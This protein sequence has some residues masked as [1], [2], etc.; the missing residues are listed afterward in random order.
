MKTVGTSEYTL[1]ITGIQIFTCNA[2]CN[3]NQLVTY[4]ICFERMELSTVFTNFTQICDYPLDFDA[5]NNNC[6]CID[7]Y[8]FSVDKCVNIE[9]Q[10]LSVDSNMQLLTLTMQY[11]LSQTVY[12]LNQQLQEV[13]Q[14]INDQLINISNNLDIHKYDTKMELNSINNT[15]HTNLNNN[16]DNI[17]LQF[18]K[19]TT[20][21]QVINDQITQ[22]KAESVYKL[23]NVYQV[24]QDLKQLQTTHLTQID[25]EI[26]NVEQKLSSSLTNIVNTVAACS[27]E[28][29]LNN[30]VDFINRQ[31]NELK[32]KMN[33]L[34][35]NISNQ[36]SGC[37]TVGA[38]PEGDGLC[39]CTQKFGIPPDTNQGYTAHGY[40]TIFYPLYNQCCTQYFYAFFQYES[41]S[42]HRGQYVNVADATL[43]YCSNQQQY[44][45]ISGLEAQNQPR[46]YTNMIV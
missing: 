17:N 1:S 45:Y 46:P 44:T 9:Q 11:E 27:K 33:E 8:Y 29:T 32:A 6:F 12:V 2:V 19:I 18:N 7:G 25:S 20:S 15:L 24:V 36:A 4:G 31:I 23:D 34:S 13:E 37:K 5:I 35:I 43:F 42:S 3:E 14:K 21:Q 16:K 38:T 39:R 10:F 22:L 41:S 28:V 40:N 30:Q 26:S